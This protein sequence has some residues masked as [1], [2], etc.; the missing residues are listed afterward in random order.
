MTSC[1]WSLFKEPQ[2]LLHPVHGH[3]LFCDLIQ[4]LEFVVIELLGQVYIDLVGIY[5]TAGFLPEG[6]LLLQAVVADLHG[7]FGFIDTFSVFEERDHELAQGVLAGLHAG[8]FP[9]LDGIEE[10]Q[11]LI[12]GENLF[13][14][15]DQVSLDL[16]GRLL[17]DAVD[18][19]V[20]GV[21]DLLRVLGEFDLG[22]KIAVVILDS[23]QLVDAAE[24]RIV[25]GRDQVRAHAPG[26]DGRALAL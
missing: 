21:R 4:E 2:R 12:L 24:G 1:E 15:A 18:L 9:G 19:F 17:V 22:D 20:A 23:R 14:E 25:L 6:I 10:L 3:F 26:G 13:L 11:R 5:E 16:V 7:L 8:P